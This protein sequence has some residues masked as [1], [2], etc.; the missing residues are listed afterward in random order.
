[1]SLSRRGFTTALLTVPATLL[2]PAGGALAG[3]GDLAV[4]GIP[5]AILPPA[6]W[7]PYYPVDPGG[8]RTLDV[9]ANGLPANSPSVDAAAALHALIARTS[10]RRVLYFPAGTYYFKT[11]LKIT[12]GDIILRGAGASRTTLR[13]AAAGA[14]N[15]ELR[16]EGSPTGPSVPVVGDVNSGD[17]RVTVTDARSFAV[18]D[19]VHLH[20][21]QGRVAYSVP[22]VGQLCRITAISGNSVSLDMKNGMPLPAGNKPTL[23]K[24]RPLRN[25]GVAQLRIERTAGP[26]VENVNNLV[27][28]CTQNAYVTDVESVKSG[29]GHISIEW[30]RDAYVAR[31]FLHDSFVKELGGYAYGVNVH[32]ASTRV[33]V[34]NNKMWDLR[35]HVVLQMGANHCVVAYNSL[36]APY[37]SYNDCALHANFAFMNL[38]EGNFMREGYADNSKAGSMSAT[39]PYN[40]W[41]RNHA[42]GKVGSI[43]GE[44]R[45][46]NVIG[47]I[48]G[49]LTLSGAYNWAGANLVAGSVQWGALNSG[50]S[51]PP[52]LYVANPPTF[53]QSRS[54]PVFGPGVPGWGGSTKLPATVRQ[55]P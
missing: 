11:T 29:R 7:Q 10:G 40:T 28:R 20:L 9:T 15:A 42:S 27:F 38:F 48:V 50:S 46:Q 14:A 26:T 3:A 39:G 55:R 25:I 41:F 43:N 24:L 33:Y 37:L 1:M 12:V 51:L 22:T 6:G 32:S 13:I 45:R 8:W 31:T 19:V 47:N 21:A 34:V 44:T 52:S 16:F 30:T 35:H 18:G 49:A 4:G 23:R 36:E 2:L 54:W 5:P 53:I 17:T